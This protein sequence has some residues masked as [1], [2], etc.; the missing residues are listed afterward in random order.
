MLLEEAG[1]NGQRDEL[2]APE[3]DHQPLG[4]A[5]HRAPHP[6]D[7]LPGGARVDC[8]VEPDD[9]RLQGIVAHGACAQP[10]ASHLAGPRLHRVDER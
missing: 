1:Q 5:T 8:P 2:E 3:V 10:G 6:R 9:E 4:R 7:E